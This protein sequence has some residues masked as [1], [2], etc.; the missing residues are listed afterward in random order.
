MAS[1]TI[2]IETDTT[3][4]D[5]LSSY[6]AAH[7]TDAFL[8]DVIRGADAGRVLVDI[9]S[10]GIEGRTLRFVAVPSRWLRELMLAHGVKH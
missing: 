9:K 1:L 3:L 8:S 6:R 2:N 4:V 7:G 10:L 5:W